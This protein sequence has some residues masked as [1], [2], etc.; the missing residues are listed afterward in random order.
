MDNKTIR[1]NVRL[2]KATHNISFKEIAEKT[3]IKYPTFL[4]WLNNQFDFSYDKLLKINNLL[5]KLNER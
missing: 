3:E 5:Y 1:K 4:N 2:T